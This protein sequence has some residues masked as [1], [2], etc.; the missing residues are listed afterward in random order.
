MNDRILTLHPE[1]KQGVKI[2]KKKYEQIKN[3]ILLVL[4]ERGEIAFKDL[5]DAVAQKL[6]GV[7]EGSIIWYVV[8]VKLDL[9]ARGLLVR[10]PK[11][12]PQRIRRA[13]Q[14]SPKAKAVNMPEKKNA[15]SM[16]DEA[17]RAKTERT[18]KEWFAL[19]DQAGAKKLD[20][21][22]IVAI[23]GEQFGLGPW[24]RQMV[25]VEYERAR[26][27]RVKH[28]TAAGF[29]V[30]RSKVMATAIA[31]AYAACD[32]AKQRAR[33][34]KAKGYAIRSATNNKSLR[35]LWNDGKTTV[36]ISFYAKGESKTQVVIEHNKLAS[37]TEAKR[38]QSFWSESLERLQKI[39]E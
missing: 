5:P 16:S 39:L 19:L 4:R 38:M 13:T 12:T 34:L 11:K 20:H 15:P 31:Q 8:T 29:S 27:L 7:F 2:S 36:N 24:W 14:K 6:D 23:L 25:A 21:K 10:V 1:G 17:V 30:S 37:A 33:W 35:M 22:G 26:G 28:E 3:A 18:W 9:E 32:D